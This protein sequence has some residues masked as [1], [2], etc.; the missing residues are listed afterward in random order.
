MLFHC[1][2]LTSVGDILMEFYCKIPVKF[3]ENVTFPYNGIKSFFISIK[4]PLFYQY[5]YI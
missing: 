5:F 4:V 3:Y 1:L 2:E